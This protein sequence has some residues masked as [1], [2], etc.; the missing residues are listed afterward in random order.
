VSLDEIIRATGHHPSLRAASASVDLALAQSFR[1]DAIYI[2]QATIEAR[3][4]V[5][6]QMTG[7]PFA[8]STDFDTVGPFFD[9]RARFGVPIEQM[10]QIHAYRELGNAAVG[11]AESER[12]VE[13]QQLRLR[14]VEAYTDWLSAAE[15]LSAV[16]EAE[17]VLMRI[18]ARLEQLEDND[19][20][21]FDPVD[22]MKA[23]VR[24][25]VNA[26]AR[27]AAETRVS[28]STAVVRG[29]LQDD[30]GE[31]IVPDSPSQQPW[32]ADPPPLEE[33]LSMALELRPE[34]QYARAALDGADAYMLLAITQ[35]LPGLAV[36]GEATLRYSG[37]SQVQRGL[38]NRDPYNAQ[39][40]GAVLGG[41]WQLDLGSR[42]ADVYVARARRGLAE[43]LF[44]TWVLRLR[45]D[46]VTAHA[47]AL[48]QKSRVVAVERAWKAA[49]GWMRA[50]VPMYEQG[51]IRL[52][53]LLGGQTAFLEQG[54]RKA[55]ATRDYNRA[56]ARLQQ[57]AGAPIGPP[58]A[59]DASL[60]A[61]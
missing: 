29:L 30:S 12:S 18:V 25:A 31:P 33:L 42:I 58:A 1:A 50:R 26:E 34:I 44:D 51:L 39:G 4:G 36:V 49:R 32:T 15:E 40:V 3:V 56:L 53:D 52:D 16:L 61:P 35:F 6:P 8:G 46:L 57:L 60:L 10:G 2:P 22:A 48:R 13:A 19:A 43:Q 5:M 24:K 7:S 59:G 28:V 9:S 54:V 45:A 17:D 21:D 27:L 11:M 37:V 47:D 41:R 14:A 38:F 20:A 23:R 55:Q